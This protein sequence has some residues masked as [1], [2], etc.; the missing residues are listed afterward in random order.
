M[1]VKLNRIGKNAIGRISDFNIKTDREDILNIWLDS[2]TEAHS[3]IE[4]KF[5]KDNIRL[6]DKG[7]EELNIKVYKKGNKIL[8]FIAISDDFVHGIYIDKPYRNKNIGSKLM[9]YVKTYHNTLKIRVYKK[10]KPAYNFAEKNGF[11]F[12]EALIDESNGERE[13]ILSWNK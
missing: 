3:F 7:L 10:N 9:D 13:D 6:V 4:P 8:G 2:S 12:Q 5:W 1:K 11:H